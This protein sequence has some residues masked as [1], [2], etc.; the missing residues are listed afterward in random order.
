M[1]VKMKKFFEDMISS[2]NVENNYQEDDFYQYKL[3]YS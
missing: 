2:Q 1:K 3:D